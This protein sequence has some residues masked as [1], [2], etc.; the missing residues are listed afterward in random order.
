M[1]PPVIS[2]VSFNITLAL[3]L[4]SCSTSQLKVI[5]DGKIYSEELIS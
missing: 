4:C 5:G 2:L 1:D 3:I